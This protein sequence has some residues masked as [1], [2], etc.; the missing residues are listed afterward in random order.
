MGIFLFV[1]MKTAWRSSIAEQRAKSFE[2]KFTE[3]L[4]I[5]RSTSCWIWVGCIGTRGYGL[6]TVNKKTMSAHRLSYLHFVG[7]IPRGMFVCHS[8][9]NPS[10]VNPRHLWVGTPKDNT[11]DMMQ[12]GRRKGPN[13]R[14]DA[15]CLHGHKWNIANTYRHPNGWRICRKCR[16]ISA[17]KRKGEKVR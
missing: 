14:N 2:E 15:H 5:D 10:C 11:A 3:K 4:L 1:K 8:C 13:K 7:D 6:M 9:D 17:M 12:K 16:R